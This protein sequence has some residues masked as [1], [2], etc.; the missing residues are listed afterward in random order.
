MSNKTQEL[1]YQQ[2]VLRALLYG[3]EQREAEL[4]IECGELRAENER[5]CGAAMHW[6]RVED[7]QLPEDDAIALYK[8][9]P[10][11]ISPKFYDY[12]S[13]RND[14]PWWIPLPPL[15]EEEK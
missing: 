12:E 13:N 3:S 15:P 2:E 8:G 9:V 14:A 5:L 7:D 10:V 6:R 11:V 1:L 4:E